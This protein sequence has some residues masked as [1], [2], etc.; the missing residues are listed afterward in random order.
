VRTSQST[1]AQRMFPHFARLSLS[2]K[3]K[4]VT[5]THFFVAQTATTGKQGFSPKSDLKKITFTH[6]PTTLDQTPSDYAGLAVVVVFKIS[7]KYVGIIRSLATRRTLGIPK[8]LKCINKAQPERERSGS[9]VIKKH[10]Y[11]TG[12]RAMLTKTE[13]SG[14]G[15][16]SFLEE[17]RSPGSKQD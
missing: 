7:S 5:L 1:P 13:S 6:S 15:A 12:A 3:T 17:F 10:S 11:G 4:S 16:I 8:L 9:H 14:A 2:A